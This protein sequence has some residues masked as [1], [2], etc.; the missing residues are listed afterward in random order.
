MKA[1]ANYVFEAA[2]VA[3]DVCQFGA[4]VLNI[5]SARAELREV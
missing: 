4:S 1:K 3:T 5:M 2:Y